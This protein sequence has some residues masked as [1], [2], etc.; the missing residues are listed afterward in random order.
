MNRAEV[1]NLEIRRENGRLIAL[2]RINAEKRRKTLATCG[3][4]LPVWLYWRLSKRTYRKGV[5]SR[6]NGLEMALNILEVE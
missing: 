5:E 1:I 6:L 3:L 2:G 4:F